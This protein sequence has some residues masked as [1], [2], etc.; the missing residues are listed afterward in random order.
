MSKAQTGKRSSVP[1]V[2]IVDPCVQ[3]VVAPYCSAII[4]CARF[5]RLTDTSAN[6]L[7]VLRSLQNLHSTTQVRCSPGAFTGTTREPPSQKG[8]LVLWE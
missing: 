5:H 6:A 4:S 2:L 1:V 8:L 3:A 7:L